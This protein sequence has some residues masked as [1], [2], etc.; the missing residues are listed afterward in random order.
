MEVL[1]RILVGLFI[2]LLC[3]LVPLIYGL[4]TKHKLSSI[5]SFVLT[6]LMGVVFAYI[7]ESP[8][9]AIVVSMLF[10]LI[11]VAE[12][13]KHSKSNHSDDE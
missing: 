8:F 5:I 1:K 13:K 9:S 11:S 12:K 6:A 2:G 4:L 3:G 10:I 7:E